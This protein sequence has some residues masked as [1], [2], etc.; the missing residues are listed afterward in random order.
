MLKA[1]AAGI[2]VASALAPQALTQQALTEQECTVGDAVITWGF[3]ESFRSYISGSIAQ[4]EW[5]VEGDVTYATPHFHFEQGTGSI[6]PDRSQGHIRYDGSFTFTGHAGILETQLS[7]P[8]LSFTSDSTAT[9]FLDV[10]G[11][12]MDEL[13]VARDGVA[14]ATV[15]WADESVNPEAGTWSISDAAVVLTEEGSSAFG[16]YPAGEALDPLDISLTVTPGCF[17]EAQQPWALVLGALGLGALVSVMG[18]VFTR[19]RKSR[20]QGRQ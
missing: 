15:S 8:L 4:G 16:T 13:S 11:D 6:S 12:T 19:V 9:L 14:F 10:L 17:E 1:L 5:L 2:V 3:K 20:E 7:N 18:L